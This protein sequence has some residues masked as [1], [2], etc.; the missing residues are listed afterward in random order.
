M[1]TVIFP[2]RHIISDVIR[3]YLCVFVISDYVIMKP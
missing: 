2:S 1:V 3:N